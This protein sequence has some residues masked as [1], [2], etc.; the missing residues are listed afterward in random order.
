MP[1][2]DQFMNPT[3]THKATISNSICI[4]KRK[5]K[6]TMNKLNITSKNNNE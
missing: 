6:I 2:S 1:S 3:V 4:Y 5:L